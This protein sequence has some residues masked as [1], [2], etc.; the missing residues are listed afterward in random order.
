MG[1]PFEHLYF[2]WLCSRVFAIDR[3]NEKDFQDPNKTY[4]NLLKILHQTEFVWLVPN[5][6]NRIADVKDLRREFLLLG[7]IPDDPDWRELVDGVSV[8]EVLIA[9]SRR[10]WF[11]TEDPPELWFWEFIQNL[12]LLKCTDASNTDPYYIGVVLDRFIWRTYKYGGRGGLFP[13]RKPTRDQRKVEIW[14]QFCDYLVDQ[15]RL[16]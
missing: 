8:L 3:R 7:E 5:D 13:L 11:Q 10:A 6:D 1:E 15:N 2:N 9:F 12:G 4:W 14:Y 16:P